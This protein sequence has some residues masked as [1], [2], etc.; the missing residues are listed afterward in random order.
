MNCFSFLFVDLAGYYFVLL[1]Y[2]TAYCCC[3]FA[4][5]QAA[6]V[7]AGYFVALLQACCL[8]ALGCCISLFGCL[9][10]VL[11]H[12]FALFCIFPMLPCFCTWQ[13]AVFVLGSLLFLI[14]FALWSCLCNA[15][16]ILFFPFLWTKKGNFF[17]ICNWGMW[18]VMKQTNILIPSRKP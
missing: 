9:L 5:V 17:V 10:P 16:K 4:S 12:S 3:Y 14:C 18:I 2:L 1:C 6:I 8:A 13:F 11:L 15:C 7:A